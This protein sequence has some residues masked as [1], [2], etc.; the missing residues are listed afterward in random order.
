MSQGPRIVQSQQARLG[1]QL[2]DLS[3]LHTRSPHKRPIVLAGVDSWGYR[4]TGAE[5]NSPL[6]G[7]Q[8]G[9]GHVYG[10]TPVDVPCS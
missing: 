3:G 5:S 1:S 7:P 10:D 4:G 2:G 6:C 8:Q 9:Q